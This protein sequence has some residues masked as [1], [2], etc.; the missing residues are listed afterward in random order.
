MVI[1]VEDIEELK[2]KLTLKPLILYGMGTIGMEISYWLD[3]QQIEYTFV[4][5][6]AIEKQK[7]VD[8]PV[9]TPESLK[10]D[11]MNANII[12]STNIYFDEIKTKLLETGFSESQIIPYTLFVPQNI[13]WPDLEDNINWDLMKPS[14]ELFSKWIDENMK[15][16]VDYGAGQMYLKTFLSK[17]VKYYPIDYMKRFD[18]TIVCD[19][20]K[21]NFPDLQADV[22]VLNGV[23]EFLITAEDLIKHVCEKTKNM[24][25][26]SY[27]TVDKFPNITGRRTSGYLSDLTEL[28]IIHL[29]DDGGFK[30]VKKE[31]DPLDNTDTIYLFEKK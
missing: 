3:S 16:V 15:S 17:D 22:A 25:I 27:M 12:V 18:D 23:L 8:K 29:L 30:L 14:V 20:N 24:I 6:N 26:I 7:L 13:V 10:T 4:D 2:K 9:V 21:G 19:L 31:S 11:F 1:K 28:K 5:R